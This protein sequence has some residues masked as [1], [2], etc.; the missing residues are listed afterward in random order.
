LGYI[1]CTSTWREK[2]TVRVTIRIKVKVTVGVVNN[3]GVNTK[4]KI[5][6]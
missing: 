6:N 4:L 1:K 3:S 2:V 5:G